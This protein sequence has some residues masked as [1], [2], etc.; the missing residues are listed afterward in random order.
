MSITQELQFSVLS[1]PLA[2]ADRRVLSQAW[3]SALYRPEAPAARQP[4]ARAQGAEERSAS[5]P[6]AKEER[7]RESIRNAP[8]RAVHVQRAVGAGIADR[9]APRLPLARKIA[10][11]VARPR[12]K[13]SGATFTIDG[14]RGR[15]RVLVR[16][17]GNRVRLIALCAEPMKATVS[18]ALAQARYTL[19]ARGASVSA[20]VWERES[21]S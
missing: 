1:A 12:R 7:A 20:R 3:Y 14:A 4:L 10:L 16:A 17:D 21:C 6:V 2:A 18:A 13:K 15:V 8:G 11:F 19:A 5:H 9:R